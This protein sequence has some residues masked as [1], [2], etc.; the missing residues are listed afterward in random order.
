M[1]SFRARHRAGIRAEEL[2]IL[3]RGGSLVLATSSPVGAE[4]NRYARRAAGRET[5]LASYAGLGKGEGTWLPIIIA[6][7][8]F[9]TIAV[10]LSI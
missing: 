9:G 4:L 8:L 2:A 10:D 3:T 5:E 1:C 7:A 6:A